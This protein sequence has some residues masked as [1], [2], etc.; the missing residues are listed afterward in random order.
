MRDLAP[1]V[2]SNQSRI[3][4]KT[5]ENLKSLGETTTSNSVCGHEP[6]HLPP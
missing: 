1:T 4:A 2:G 6:Y 3:T 5:Q